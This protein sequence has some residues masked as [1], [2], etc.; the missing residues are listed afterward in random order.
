MN[1]NTCTHYSYMYCTDIQF[2]THSQTC[3]NSHLLELSGHQSHA[4]I[5][6]PP[7]GISFMKYKGTL[8][9]THLCITE[10]SRQIS[11]QTAISLCLQQP[12][13]L[14]H[15]PYIQFLKIIYTI[16]QFPTDSI[17]KHISDLDNSQWYDFRTLTDQDM[18]STTFTMI[19]N[20]ETYSTNWQGQMTFIKELV[21][22]SNL[23]CQRHGIFINNDWMMK[24]AH[25]Y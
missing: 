9:G 2:V 13:D 14:S 12:F 24:L 10:N 15:E 19:L 7:D 8:Y 21:K 20:D 18:E 23:D 17:L 22:L 11:Y 3:Y 6:L 16:R 5:L 25:Q 1:I 4:V